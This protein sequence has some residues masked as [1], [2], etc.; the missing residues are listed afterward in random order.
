MASPQNLT[1]PPP[2]EWYLPDGWLWSQFEH[3]CPDPR[4]FSGS[5]DFRDALYDAQLQL[6]MNMESTTRELYRAMWEIQ[7]LEER[8]EAFEGKAGAKNARSDRDKWIYDSVCD[9]DAGMDSILFKLKQ[10]CAEHDWPNSIG[11]KEGVRLAAIRYAK[12]K[13]L[14]APPRRRG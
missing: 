9:V 14:P 10:L 5:D 13:G 3:H 4:S 7:R 1:A 12:S 6:C 11:T 2:E 8:L